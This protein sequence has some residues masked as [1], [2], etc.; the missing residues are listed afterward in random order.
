MGGSVN[1]FMTNV[2]IGDFLRSILKKGSVGVFCWEF[3]G[4]H[5]GGE[6]CVFYGVERF[7]CFMGLISFSAFLDIA[8]Y[9]GD[10][11]FSFVSE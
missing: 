9:F 1:S 5:W 4:L 3:E 10:L 11:L 7:V 6:T 2:K 8:T